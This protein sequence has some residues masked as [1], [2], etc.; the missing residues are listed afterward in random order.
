M[1]HIQNVMKKATL[2]AR[3]GITT[4]AQEV[5]S[6]PANSTVSLPRRGLTG[7]SSDADQRMKDKM[8]MMD[9]KTGQ[10]PFGLVTASDADFRLIE[11]KRRVA[12]EANFDR[13]IGEKYHK[14]DVVKRKWLQDVVPEYY[15]AREQDIDER[16]EFAKTVAKLK[17]R[18]PRTTD[19]MILL[20][21]LMEGK[22][23]LEDGWN[24]I[25]Y[26]EEG[27]SDTDRFNRFKGNLFGPYRYR[28]EAERKT[29]AGDTVHNP[30]NQPNLSKSLFPMTANQKA[31][32]AAIFADI[33][34]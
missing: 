31:D 21:G 25:G 12:E 8:Q 27:K 6:D 18:G 34:K 15:D 19:E 11:Q 4:H 9:P 7:T 3:P 13:W 14:G 10:S 17:L 2:A 33:K 26:A 30:F 20:Y 23:P 32:F 1:A 29:A 24:V 16:A 5:S 22:I 28:T